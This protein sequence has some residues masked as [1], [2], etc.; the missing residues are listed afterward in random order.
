MKRLSQPFVLLGLFLMTSFTVLNAEESDR[1]HGGR[2]GRG[3]W[4]MAAIRQRM[5]ERMKEMLGSSDEE[6]KLI[7]PM[8][9]KVQSIQRQTRA[10]G[11]SMWRG[12]SR[13]SQQDGEEREKSAIEKSAEALKKILDNKDSKPEEIKAAL[14]D[15]RAQ[16]KKVQDE[17]KI[18]QQ[19][20][21]EVL[22]QQQEA[23]LVLMGTLD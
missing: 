22:T 11:R 23:N 12:R 4:D 10:G 5:A 13:S 7:Q 21:G 1:G 3:G 15:Y 2:G 6:W 16:R 20:L 18:A 19:K 14:E 17:L 8:I 9:E